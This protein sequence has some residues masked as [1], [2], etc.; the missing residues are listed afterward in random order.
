M[1]ITFTNSSKTC[2]THFF[3]TSDACKW[4]MP[5]VPYFRG[6]DKGQWQQEQAGIELY[7]QNFPEF[8]C[9]GRYALATWPVTVA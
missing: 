5:H 6:S 8:P 7:L 9:E 1:N 4:L 3:T 2:G